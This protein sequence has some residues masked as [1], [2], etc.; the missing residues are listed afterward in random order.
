[1]E[2]TLDMV[3]CFMEVNSM[4]LGSSINGGNL[5]NRGMLG[6]RRE[7]QWRGSPAVEGIMVAKKSLGGGGE[8]RW[9]RGTREVQGI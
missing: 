4:A 5:D 6:W 1:M 9:Q 8:S 7:S 2:T 3:L